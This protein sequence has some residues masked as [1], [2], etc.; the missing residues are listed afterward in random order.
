[1]RLVKKM[2]DN[3]LSDLEKLLCEKCKN[4]VD[5]AEKQ[6]D[7][8]KMPTRPLC[9]NCRQAIHGHF[10]TLTGLHV[11]RREFEK[12]LIEEVGGRKN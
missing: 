10:I 8:G 12:A 4:K 9:K 5:K 7:R 3:P 1:M 6:I 11:T 2:E